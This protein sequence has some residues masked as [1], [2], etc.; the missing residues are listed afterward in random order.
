MPRLL[1]SNLEA[2]TTATTW[3]QQRFLTFKRALLDIEKEQLDEENSDREQ[4]V[5][6]FTLG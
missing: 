3:A 4:Q 2:T 1:K 5:R 6:Q